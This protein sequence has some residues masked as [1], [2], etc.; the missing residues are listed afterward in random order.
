MTM[1]FGSAIRPE[2][3]DPEELD[4]LQT[5]AVSYQKEGDASTLFSANEVHAL[6]CHLAHRE[7]V[8]AGQAKK[9]NAMREA[10]SKDLHAADETIH[11]LQEDLQ[12]S[13]RRVSELETAMHEVHTQIKALRADIQQAMA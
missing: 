4:R 1:H 10:R 8:I 5:V 11:R 2:A 3:M 12:K 9:I 7:D 13:S 6:L